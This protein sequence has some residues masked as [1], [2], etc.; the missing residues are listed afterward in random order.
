[1]MLRSIKM[2]LC[3]RRLLNLDHLKTPGQGGVL[4]E[5][6]FI[7][8]PGRCRD[9]AEGAA[10][11]GRFEQIGGIAGAGGAARADECVGLVNEEDDWLG[12]LLHFLDDLA[13]ALLKFAF[14]A[15]A[16]LEQTDVKRAQ[17]NVLQHR[18]HVTGDDAHGKTFHNSRLAHA[19]LTGEDGVVLAPAHEDVHNLADFL[20]AA[21]NGVQ[22]AF[23]RFFRQVHG[24][25]GECLLFAMTA[26]AMAPLVSTRRGA[27][28]RAIAGGKTVLRRT[29]DDF[30]ELVGQRLQFDFG[31]LAESPRKP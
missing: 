17:R 16:G 7:F 28:G 27:A 13:E 19:G 31:K 20:V 10:G 29:T 2:G 11:E 3:F 30:L 23:A 21:D 24:E 26:G 5:M 14:H 1:M 4:L 22:F 25:A 12:R 8:V 18:R 15:G 9:G 6:F